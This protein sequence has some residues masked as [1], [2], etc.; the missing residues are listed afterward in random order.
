M[1]A[2]CESVAN[3]RLIE[4][5]QRKGVWNKTPSINVITSNWHSNHVVT[6]VTANQRSSFFVV[7]K[8]SHRYISEQQCHLLDGVLSPYVSVH[9]KGGLQAGHWLPL[10]KQP[11]WPKSI[12]NQNW[13]LH[14]NG[15]VGCDISLKRRQVL[16]VFP[17]RLIGCICHSQPWYPFVYSVDSTLSSM[18]I[19]GRAHS[20]SWTWCCSCCDMQQ[21]FVA[22]QLSCFCLLYVCFRRM[23]WNPYI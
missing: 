8:P 4:W 22:L 2:N 20:W 23:I 13:P 16:S 5:K 21:V 11:P 9:W 10:T 7:L 17:A 12:P 6:M 3:V 1:F 18:G 14:W 15:S 19:T